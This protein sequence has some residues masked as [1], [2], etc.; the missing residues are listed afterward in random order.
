[1]EENRCAGH[2]PTWFQSSQLAIYAVESARLTNW[3]GLLARLGPD[4]PNIWSRVLDFLSTRPPP[5][6]IFKAKHLVVVHPILLCVK[7]KREKLCRCVESWAF[8]CARAA[9][10]LCTFEKRTRAVMLLMV[11]HARPKSRAQTS[12]F[13]LSMYS[14]S[15]KNVMPLRWMKGREKRG[16]GEEK[17]V[18]NDD[19]RA[20][21]EPILQWDPNS[22][23]QLALTPALFFLA[24]IIVM[25]FIRI[26]QRGWTRSCSRSN[27]F[28][29][30]IFIFALRRG[31][32][33]CNF[34]LW[35]LNIN[36][37]QLVC[38]V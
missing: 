34:R 29:F 33:I 22:P 35:A 21:L 19:Y 13:S 15:C 31:W 14:M 7:K 16:R 37:N 10:A 17:L 4:E 20:T 28:F 3:F 30:L 18:E 36:V 23:C 11:W 5:I 8:G 38:G 9:R 12:C 6:Q 32:N 2:K 27:F 1:M 24:I 26:T 25:W